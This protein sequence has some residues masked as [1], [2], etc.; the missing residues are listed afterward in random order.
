MTRKKTP[1]LPKNML[2]CT[3]NASLEDKVR[4]KYRIPEETDVLIQWSEDG[5]CI[6]S[7]IVGD[8][9]DVFSFLNYERV[10]DLILEFFDVTSVQML[11]E[12]YWPD[13]SSHR[14]FENYKKSRGLTDPEIRCAA[15]MPEKY[16]SGWE[17]IYNQRCVVE[18]GGG[19]I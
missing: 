16:M 3:F 15:D 12:Y 13:N 1:P 14:S 17:D 9:D 5:S 2:L 11:E 19:G 10:Q 18:L 4:I 6:C 7:I 8:V